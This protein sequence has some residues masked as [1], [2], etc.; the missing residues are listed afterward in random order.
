MLAKYL[1]VIFDIVVIGL[2]IRGIRQTLQ[3]GVYASKRWGTYRR[4]HDDRYWMMVGAMAIGGI[5]IAVKLVVFV[6]QNFR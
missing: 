5:V 3:S 6:I 2:L 1:V 4:N